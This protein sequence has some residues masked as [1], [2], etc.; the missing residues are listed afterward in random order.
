MKKNA[1]YTSKIIFGIIIMI[2]FTACPSSNESVPV[3]RTPAIVGQFT[4]TEWKQ[5]AGWDDYSASDYTPNA[6]I[7]ASLKQ[8]IDMN[9]IS[10][11]MFSSNWC[12]RDC[13]RYM[14]RIMKLLKEIGYEQDSILIYGLSRDKIEPAVPVQ[15]YDIKFVPTLVILKNDIEI[16]KIVVERPNQYPVE[17]WEADILEILT[18]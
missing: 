12:I 10:F 7:L 5:Q 13:G 3:T 11:I 14:P 9:E 18:N 16:G 4:W 8:L 1:I 17:T 15:Q 6:E 2:T